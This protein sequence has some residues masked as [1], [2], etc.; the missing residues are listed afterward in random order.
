MRDNIGN[1]A[2][3][4]TGS[5]GRRL[6]SLLFFALL[7]VHSALAQQLKVGGSGSGLAIMNHLATAYTKANPSVQVVVLPSLGSTGGIKAVAS[8][9]IDVAVSGRGLKPDETSQGL[10]DIDLARTPVCF[11]T[12]ANQSANS[13][14]LAEINDVFAGRRSNWPDGKPI[15]LILRPAVDSSLIPLRE[16]SKD[17][18]SALL[19]ALAKP[20]YRVATTDQD[21]AQALTTISGALGIMTLGQLQAEKLTLKPIALNGV[22]PTTQTLSTKRYPLSAPLHV[23]LGPKASA[24]ARQFASFLK[25]KAAATVLTENGFLPVKD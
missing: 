24:S 5:K 14:T 19:A 20:G 22:A 7:T 15:R 17:F 1:G 23:V 8:G 16:L 2:P 9:E 12:P 25:T 11:V 6:L 3:A 21:N 13:M 4:R 10:S 18:E